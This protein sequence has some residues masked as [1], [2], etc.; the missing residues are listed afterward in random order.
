MLETNFWSI[1]SILWPLLILFSVIMAI[2]IIFYIFDIKIKNL[3]I[4]KRFQKGAQL[5]S[6]RDIIHQLQN[7][8][9]KDFEHYI[10]DLFSRL[11]HKAYVVGGPNDDGVDVIA[12]KDGIKHYI[13]CKKYFRKHQ[14]G[15]SEMRDFYGAITDKLTNGKAYFI[16]TNKFT[17]SAEKFAEDKPIELV[18]SYRLINYIHLAEK[19]KEESKEQTDEEICPKCGGRLIERKSKHGRFYGCSNYPKCRY[20]KNL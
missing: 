7:M 13:Q 4:R 19:K 12:E 5:R 15:V 6:D 17:L 16:T 2:R 9:P 10:A 20:I 18:D 14:V 1:F 11:D 3:N 8:T